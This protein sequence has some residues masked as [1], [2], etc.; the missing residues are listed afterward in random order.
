MRT[1]THMTIQDY[2]RH[3]GLQRIRTRVPNAAAPTQIGVSTPFAKALSTA[4]NSTTDSGRGWTIGDYLKRPIQLRSATKTRPAGTPA[5]LAA[6]DR[7]VAVAAS[8]PAKVTPPT[9]AAT[10]EIAQKQG[11]DPPAVG[12]G[13]RDRI[14][15]SVEKAA[16][17]YNLSPALIKAVIKAE[18]DY[19]VRAVSPAGAQGLMQL[20]PGTASELGVLNP[21]DV[22]QNIHGGARYLREMLDRFKGDIK[23]ALS[24]YNAGPGTGAKFNGNVPYAETQNYIQRVMRYVRQLSDAADGIS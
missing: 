5:R 1:D 4:Q 19:E 12:G 23:L 20:M 7:P 11:V 16:T 14:Q 22:D 2:F 3:R 13:E 8:Q 17:R 10:P 21:F 6:Q 24:A 18:S 9:P 15:A